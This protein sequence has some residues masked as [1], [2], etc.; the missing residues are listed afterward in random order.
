MS[1][2]I[3]ILG[4][5]YPKTIKKILT[6]PENDFCLANLE[7]VI[8]DRETS[9]S[10]DGPSLKIS[11]DKAEILKQLNV[12][13]VGLANNHTMDYGLEG[14]KD[15][16]SFLKQ[17]GVDYAGCSLGNNSFIKKISNLRIGFYFVSEHQYNDKV[18]T[19]EENRCL[20]EI[21]QLKSETDFVIV[22][23]HGGKEYYKYP[24]P[25]QQINCR[26]FV[27]SG[28]NFVVCQHS[29]CVGCKEKYKGADIVYGQGNFVFPYSNK[30]DFKSGLI[31]QLEIDNNKTYKT[32]F[33]PTVHLEENVVRFANNE[34]SNKI[35]SSFEK[36]SNNLSAKSAEYLYDEMVEQ[37]GLDFLY[38]LF[39]KGKI[40]TCLDT[41]KFFKNRMIKKYIRTNQ[42]YILYLLNYFS[43]ETHIEYIKSILA[44]QIKQGKK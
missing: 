3:I 30:Q 7:C 17:I 38:R 33:I 41:S 2:K 15:T 14:L 20:D 21:S 22:L 10:K 4:D 24:T 18:N 29:H 42:K 40:Y 23:F 35:L 26:K 6:L 13:L 5:L 16:V 11:K 25:Q 19:L 37:Y 12:N 44:K 34:E 36:C 43:C 9:I 8:T 1:V 28:A 32:T 39:N 31:I 27:E